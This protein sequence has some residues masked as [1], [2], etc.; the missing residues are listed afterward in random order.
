[1]PVQA[2]DRT[3]LRQLAVS[4]A[5]AALWLLRMTDWAK[6]VEILALR[7]QLAALQRQLGDQ[8]PRMRPED[9]SVLL[10]E[11]DGVVGLASVKREVTE[12]VNLL[13]AG[14]SASA[15]RT[16][17]DRG[18]GTQPHGVVGG[19]HVRSVGVGVGLHGYGSRQGDPR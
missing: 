2:F 14:R 13:A 9:V 17:V 3:S 4:H 15:R 12:L 6:D 19:L 5:F 10:A 11:L 16:G 18:S 8:R 1:M 7:H